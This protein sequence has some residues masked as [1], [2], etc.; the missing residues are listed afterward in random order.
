VRDLRPRPVAAAVLPRG[1]GAPETGGR[2]VL[3]GDADLVTNRFVARSRENAVFA[4]NAIDWLAADESLIGIRA[5]QRA[6]PPLLYDSAGARDAAKYLTLVGVPL[7]FVIIGLIRLAR[8]RR[9]AGRPWRPRDS[10]AT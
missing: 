10:D 9:L 7:L 1:E 3:V 6:A 5:K 4:R 8:R 2:I